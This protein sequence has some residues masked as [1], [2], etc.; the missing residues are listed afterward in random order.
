MSK[1]N[2]APRTPTKISRPTTR[3][4]LLKVDKK[5]KYCYPKWDL[6]KKFVHELEE[7][8]TTRLDAV[9]IIGEDRDNLLSE[10]FQKLT[11]EVQQAEL[12]SQAPELYAERADKSEKPEAFL[13][14]V[15]DGLTGTPERPAK[16]VR[17]HIKAW[18]HRLYEALY[19]R[20][21]IIDNF[22]TLL[23]PSQ[24]KS[25]DDLSVSSSDFLSRYRERDAARKRQYRA[26]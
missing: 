8:I 19:K 2:A 20:R 25:V 23:P 1:N 5:S 26:S 22:E 13:V 6:K 3:R 16:I 15:Y 4:P 14:R 12:P 9:G 10:L 17:S 11:A 21:K 7:L 18:D 24:G